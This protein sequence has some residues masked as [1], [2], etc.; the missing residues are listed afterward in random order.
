MVLL[1]LGVGRDGD[2]E[3]NESRRAAIGKLIIVQNKS[4]TRNLAKNFSMAQ[5]R[6]DVPLSRG[7]AMV[8]FC[9]WPEITPLANARLQSPTPRSRKTLDSRFPDCL[10]L[11]LQTNAVAI[12]HF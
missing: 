2:S 12:R 6:F 4:M 5:T 8:A 3:Q 10:L 1:R 11:L 7:E 9:A